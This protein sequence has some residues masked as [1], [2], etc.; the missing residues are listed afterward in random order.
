[1]CRLALNWVLPHLYGAVAAFEPS[2]AQDLLCRT[3]RV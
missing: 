1:M 3:L 2:A